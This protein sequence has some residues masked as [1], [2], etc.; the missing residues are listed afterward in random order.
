MKLKIPFLGFLFYVL[1]VLPVSASNC[2]GII[3]NINADIIKKQTLLQ[4][5]NFPWQTLSWLQK[6]L[7]QTKKTLNSN[8]QIQ[9]TWHCQSN[10]DVFL[11]A[12]VDKIGAITQ[13][14]GAYSGEN[15]AGIFSNVF[16]QSD[17]NN[18][19]A[20]SNVQQPDIQ[21]PSNQDKSGLIE[22]SSQVDSQTDINLSLEQATKDFKKWFDMDISKDK[23]KTAALE[24]LSNYYQKLKQCTP[25]NYKYP[26]INNFF[27][28]RQGDNK[29]QPFAN[30]GITTIAGYKN[31]KCVIT[32]GSESSAHEGTCEFTQDSLDFLADKKYASGME[33]AAFK[34]KDDLN[35]F[36][37]IMTTECAQ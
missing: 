4:Q 17:E 12:S 13:V 3:N 19:G 10:S 32:I 7:G 31:G 11:T 35:K 33:N 5:H 18:V 34:S 26:L 8:N 6:K 15:G 36:A 2:V 27:G 30:L 21:P 28:M 20:S 14:E 22:V 1:S 9:Y 37:K 24:I 23:I 16:K 25:G 29:L